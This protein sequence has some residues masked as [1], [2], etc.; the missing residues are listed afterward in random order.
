LRRDDLCPG[1]E[2]CPD[3][4]MANPFAN[5]E[6]SR[7]EECPL[8]LLENHLATPAGQLIQRTLDL[9]FALQAGVTVTLQDITYLEFL[10]L[11]FFVQERNRYQA[12]VVGRK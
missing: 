11:R 6:S 3:V 10:M 2:E 4:L 7:C 1:A 9:D 8:A 12:E 5:A